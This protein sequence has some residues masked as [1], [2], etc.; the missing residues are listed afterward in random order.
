MQRVA[1]CRSLINDPPIILADEPT[2][3]LDSM[4]SQTVA[5]ILFSLSKEK[6][7]TLIV[8]THNETLAKRADKIVKLVDG[9]VT[10]S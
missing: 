1:I 10:G 8:G 4:N 9:K 6:N 7:K 2:G 3:N 5:D